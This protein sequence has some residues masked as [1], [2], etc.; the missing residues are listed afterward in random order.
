MQSY[1]DEPYH[2]IQ[3]KNPYKPYCITSMAVIHGDIHVS[4]RQWKEIHKPDIF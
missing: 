2:T 4:G 1:D 3:G